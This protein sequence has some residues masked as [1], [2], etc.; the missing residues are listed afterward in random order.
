MHSHSDSRPDG[1]QSD[2][3]ARSGGDY[4]QWW[5]WREILPILTP[6]RL[7]GPDRSRILTAAGIAFNIFVTNDRQARG[8]GRKP[9]V[10]GL[11]SAA[12]GHA[13]ARF[14]EPRSDQDL[15]DGAKVETIAAVAR[16][17]ADLARRASRYATSE[18]CPCGGRGGL[19]PPL[20]HESIP[21]ARC[22]LCH[23]FL[24]RVRLR[25]DVAL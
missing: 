1:S 23:R 5:E 15:D 17:A 11:V 3:V 10:E 6:I 24:K 2:R 22:V 16:R 21:V 18:R 25:G 7:N 8:R 20:E 12:A 19:W 9:N 4:G 14:T 13:L